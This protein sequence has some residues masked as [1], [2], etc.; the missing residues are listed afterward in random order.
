MYAGCM[1]PEGYVVEFG[2]GWRHI[3]EGWFAIPDETAFEPYEEGPGE[4]VIPE[5]YR[6]LGMIEK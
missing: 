2:K 5:G 3:G 4:I 6:D 1:P